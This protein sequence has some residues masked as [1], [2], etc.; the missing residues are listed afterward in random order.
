MRKTFFVLL[1]C[2]INQL[3]WAQQTGIRFEKNTWEELLAKAE[4]D[5]ELV[6]LDAFTTWCGP[7]KSM[8]RNVFTDQS[9]G[10]FYNRNFVNAKIDMEKG[11]GQQ[12]A[13]KYKIEAYPSLLFINGKGEVVHRST[14]YK[15]VN[16]FLLLGET[17][18][19]PNNNLSGLTRKY[20]SGTRDAN[21]MMQYIM[22]KYNAMEE[23][24]LEV[25]E[26]YLAA[27]K[28][29][30]TLPNMQLIY[31]LTEDPDSKMFGYMVENREQFE[32]LFG[33]ENVR[34]KFQNL[35]LNKAFARGK[36]AFAEIDRFYQKAYPVVANKLSAH[37]RMN[38]YQYAGDLEAF[39]NAAIDYLDSHPSNDPSELN[40]L[41]WTFY[42][43]VDNPQRLK[44][45]LAW[46]ERS[47]ELDSQFY[48]NDTL[49]HLYFKLGKKGKAKR[50]AEKA[51]SMAKANDEDYAETE[52]LLMKIN[53]KN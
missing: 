43:A 10:K 22:A 2:L 18:L 34:A 28:D 27:E 41:A 9:V 17:A 39:A 35:F 29:W 32:T 53:G 7:C 12:I 30:S 42:D 25:A 37:F 24:L 13:R 20:H 33:K 6:F 51:I 38:Y 11:E 46:A 21:F 15:D 50:T 1:L 8:S 16:E 26:E 5:N 36:D 19:D 52:S 40:N 14:G 49:A 47:V 31:A 4:I 48:N 23:G 44:K 3:I 45:A